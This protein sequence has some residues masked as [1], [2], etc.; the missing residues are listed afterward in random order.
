MLNLMTLLAEPTQ[1]PGRAGNGCNE[2]DVMVDRVDCD[3]RAPV[4]TRQNSRCIKRK[5]NEHQC[6]SSAWT[7]GA[8]PCFSSFLAAFLGEGSGSGL[9]DMCRGR[10]PCYEHPQ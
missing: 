6:T 7:L 2:M 3:S 5:C 9:M 1:G 10:N 4:Q 8:E